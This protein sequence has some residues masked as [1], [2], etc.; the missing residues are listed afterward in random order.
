MT[1]LVFRCMRVWLGD[2]SCG[3]LTPGLPQVLVKHFRC[4]AP[5]GSTVS[6]LDGWTV[7]SALQ[8]F[9]VSLSPNAGGPAWSGLGDACEWE[10]G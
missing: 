7:I 6:P 3:L 10:N 2:I 4:M 9:N 1:I 5:R 8:L